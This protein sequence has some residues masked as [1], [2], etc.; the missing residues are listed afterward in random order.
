MIKEAIST[1]Y[2]EEFLAYLLTGK[3]ISIVI[4]AN[5]GMSVC[6]RVR[7]Y[8]GQEHSGCHARSLAKGRGRCTERKGVYPI[9]KLVDDILSSYHSQ[10]LKTK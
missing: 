1:A 7:V 4:T 6:D 10:W 8:I 3:H 2:S 9:I 5:D